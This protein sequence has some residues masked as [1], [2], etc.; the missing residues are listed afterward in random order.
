MLGDNGDLGAGGLGPVSNTTKT[1]K[2]RAKPLSTSVSHQHC[3]VPPLQRGTSVRVAFRRGTGGHERRAMS[4]LTSDYKDRAH[5]WRCPG[6]TGPR[7]RRR[8]QQRG[9][10]RAGRATLTCTKQ[11]RNDWNEETTHSGAKSAAAGDPPR[12]NTHGA[13]KGSGSVTRQASQHDWQ[14]TQ[15][16]PRDSPKL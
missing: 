1:V 3:E 13:H 2:R 10:R 11:R 14:S 7:R 15:P 5:S 6:C 8:T 4:A 9:R 16:R 12:H